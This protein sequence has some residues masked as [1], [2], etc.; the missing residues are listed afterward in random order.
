VD[1]NN[2]PVS[3]VALEHVKHV[4]RLFCGSDP[5]RWRAIAEFVREMTGGKK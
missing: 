1:S 2:R 4:I 3:D 5:T